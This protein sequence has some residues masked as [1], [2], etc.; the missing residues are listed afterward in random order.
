MCYEGVTNVPRQPVR[1]VRDGTVARV[2]RILRTQLPDGVFHVTARGVNG[3]FLF[4]DDD[5]RRMYLALLAKT[6]RR[7]EWHVDTFCLMGNH[8]HLIL[9]ARQA[10]LSAGVQYLHGRYAQSF[11]RRHGRTGHLFGARFASWVIE[12][13]DHL[14]RAREYVLDNPVAAGLTPT[15][16]A[17]R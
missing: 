15:R 9:L 6:V 13:D 3:A 14:G 17:W 16:E 5:D 4:R 10:Q 7:Y 12:T 1:V 2:P 11:N 8:V